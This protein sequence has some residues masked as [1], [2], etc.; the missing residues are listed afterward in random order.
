MIKNK[1]K[2]FWDIIDLL[3]KENALVI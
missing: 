1:Y 3:D 2:E